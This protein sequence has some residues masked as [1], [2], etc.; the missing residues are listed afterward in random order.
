MYRFFECWDCGIDNLVPEWIGCR[1]LFVITKEELFLLNKRMPDLATATSVSFLC[2]TNKLQWLVL[3]R[4]YAC[5]IAKTKFYSSPSLWWLTRL[6]DH[7]LHEL[8]LF[9]N[10][11]SCWCFVAVYLSCMDWL[12]VATIMLLDVVFSFCQ[13]H[14]KGVEM[15]RVLI[16][17]RREFGEQFIYLFG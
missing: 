16:L 9:S 13:N 11:S 14:A 12:I 7:F 4:H 10:L 15:E 3:C 5:I 17:P 2:L 8:M 6:I 1:N